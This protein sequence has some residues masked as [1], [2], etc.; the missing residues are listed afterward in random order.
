MKPSNIA[1]AVT[2]CI[3]K[4]RPVFIW[5]PVGVGKSDVVGQVAKALGR[6][7]EDVR[8]SMMD[9]VDFKGFPVPNL[10]TGQMTW[11]P[12]DFLP[13]M[14]VRADS[15]SGFKA[16]AKGLKAGDMIPNP[17]KGIIFFDEANAAVPAMQATLY[18]FTLTR[19]IGKYVLPDGWDIV[20]AG[21]REGDRSIT[22]NMPAAL[23]NRLVHLDF[24]VNNDE[25][26]TWAQDNKV[27]SEIIAFLRFRGKL[28]HDFDP[29]VNPRAF[30]TPRTWY[31]AN[32]IVKSS[33]PADIELDMLK[34]VIGEGAA[35]ELVAFLGIYKELPNIDHILVDPDGVA[36]PTKLSAL[37]AV[38]TEL[39]T[40]VARDNMDRLMKYVERLP[41]EFQVVFT[42]D[43][44]RKDI[45][46]QRA[47][48][49]TKWCIKNSDVLT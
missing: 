18:Q 32:D 23:R 8:V 45:N 49:Y 48:S 5:G 17:S 24:E 25:W 2:H 9:L 43:A 1:K 39:A 16:S 41:V 20:L 47:T 3:L 44:V 7:L 35:A 38:S 26:T 6:L 12:G 22:H 19:T 21:N 11:L 14:F 34:G 29:K 27:Q 15:V 40:R 42:R 10:V 46:V 37:Y 28:L 13:P 33:L 30:P 36:V 31:M 4:R